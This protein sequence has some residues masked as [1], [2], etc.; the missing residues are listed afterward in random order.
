MPK[1]NSLRS[2]PPPKC[3][4]CLL[5]KAKRRH[6]PGKTSRDDHTIAGILKRDD[7]MPGDK[8]SYPFYLSFF[9]RQIHDD[10]TNKEKEML[11]FP[12]SRRRKTN[13]NG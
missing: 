1:V 8:I 9:S 11:P 3:T 6:A 10:K 13:Q 2:C 4:A 12:I 5:S 7:I